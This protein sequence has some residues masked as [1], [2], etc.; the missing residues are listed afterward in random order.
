LKHTLED[1]IKGF[2]P[3]LPMAVAY[4]GGAD[5]TAL[6][7][8]CHT[9]WPGQ[10]RAVHVNHGLQ[11]A[12]LEFEAHARSFCHEQGIPLVVAQAQAFHSRG[13]SPEDAARRARYHALERVL[14]EAW[15]AQVRDVALAQHAQD[16]VE[17]VI[18]ALSRGAGLPGLS[19]MRG[20]WVRGGIAFHRPLLHVSVQELRAYNQ[21]QGLSW[22]EDPSNTD[23]RFTRNKIRHHLLPPL[24]DAFPE[25]APMMARSAKHIAQ[26]Q[27]LLVEL[28]QWDLQHVGNPPHI[29]AL[30]TLGED[31]LSNVLRHWLVSESCQASDAQLLEL[32]RQIRACQTRGHHIELKVGLSQV[33]RQGEILTLGTID[34]LPKTKV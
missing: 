24:Q 33:Q 12:A 2:E 13:Q 18:L 20:H 11:S 22:V 16:Q 32:M 19:G 21:R 1:A 10:V 28:A 34:G 17:T 4:S 26:A 31:R 8:A 30:Q 5:S 7:F 15:G 14:R 9:Q 29:K 27:R 25:I 3:H 6:L 23:T